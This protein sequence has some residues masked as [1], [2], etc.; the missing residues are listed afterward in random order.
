MRASVEA[1]ERE[2]VLDEVDPHP[3]PLRKLAR[4]ELGRQRVLQLLLDDPLQGPGAEDRVV[5]Q[6][7]DLVQA[8][9]AVLEPD[10]RLLGLPDEP[11]HLDLD[12]PADVLLVERVEDD[13]LVDAVEELGEEA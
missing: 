13:R 3:A 10:A 1:G 11:L 7:G 8:R 5:A 12:D 9:L 6:P 2:P 4:Q